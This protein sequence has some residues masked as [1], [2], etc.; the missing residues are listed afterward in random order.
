MLKILFMNLFLILMFYKK[1]NF[2]ILNSLMM[3]FLFQFF[4]SFFNFSN[5]T[6][7]FGLDK[8]SYLLIML[9]FWVLFMM[10]LISE[11]IF[12]KKNN[13]NL[14][15]LIILFLVFFLILSFSSL[16][17]LGFYI[18]FESSLVFTL[19]L[20]LG[21]GYQPERLQAGIYMLFYTLVVSL[22]FLVAI[23]YLYKNY[24]MFYFFFYKMNLLSYLMYFSMVLTFLVKMPMFLV[25][26]WLPKAHVEAPVSGSMILAGVM[27]K[28]GGY[29]LIRILEGFLFLGMFLNFY[30]MLLS[31]IG[32]L[33]ISLICL[34]Q[35]DLKSLVA[36]SSVVHMSL[37]LIGLMTMNSW[38][39]IGCL[40]LMIGHGLCSSGLFCLVSV[41]YD[42]SNSRSLLINKGLMNFMPSMCMWWFLLS[43]SNLASPPSLN[44][45]GEVSLLMSILSWSYKSMGLLMMISFFSASYS[46]Y[47]FSYSQH[48]KCYSG[49][50]SFS[51]NFIMEYLVM[52]FHWL[53]LNFL[54]LKSDLFMYM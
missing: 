8:L 46:L 38:G 26:L 45:L 23:I 25:H 35:I 44:L 2:L 7:F 54:F 17:L 9:S 43:S 47:L 21:W 14:F 10:L 42:R 41:V 50:F 22:P 5:L 1:K 20:I 28:L 27:L 51:K 36:Y 12:Y 34:L 33:L 13:I 6:Y 16:S 32:G 18:F 11:M 37:L 29:G 30:W 52:F 40:K 48:G 53:P 39:L 49:V 3:I 24:S 19:L 31:L 15:K 4:Y